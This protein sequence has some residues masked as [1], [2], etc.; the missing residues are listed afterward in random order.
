MSELGNHNEDAGRRNE[1]AAAQYDTPGPNAR[2]R[3]LAAAL[4]ALS[5]TSPSMEADA[6]PISA[7]RALRVGGGGWAVSRRRP[8]P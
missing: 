4:E 7:S 1:W 8:Q 6:T 5:G 2:K 3:A